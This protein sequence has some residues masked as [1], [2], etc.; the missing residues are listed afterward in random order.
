MNELI[1]AFNTYFEVRHATNPDLREQALKLR[2]D[3]YVRE[4]QWESGSGGVETDQY[5]R[6]SVHGLLYHR[7]TGA[8][9][10]TARLVLQDA[11]CLDALFPA[12]GFIDESLRLGI[13]D[14]KIARPRVA[15][16]SRFTLA[17]SFRS[18]TGEAANPY[19][20]AIGSGPSE[21]VQQSRDPSHRGDGVAFPF[22]QERR[23]MLHPLL[24]LF[25]WVIRASAHHE[26]A[27]L[28]ALMEPALD[29]V[30]KRFGLCFDRISPPV[31]HHGVR[32]VH[33]AHIPNFLST[34]QR[35][36]PEVWE[37]LTDEGRLCAAFM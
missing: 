15:E 33:T 17:R 3:V 31:Q 35:L 13:A 27:Y 12:E 37:L 29:R 2:Y 10:G 32:H 16:F 5:D 30:F 25:V 26:L 4:M 18:R 21:P 6:R 24:G 36:R 7:P 19:G 20:A 14:P 34:L 9:A 8:L 28:Y 11:H 1:Q 22:R 23:A